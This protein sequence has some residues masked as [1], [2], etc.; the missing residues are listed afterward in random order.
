MVRNL[1]AKSRERVGYEVIR[2]MLLGGGTE[3]GGELNREGGGLPAKM[4][5]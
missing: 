4:D 5:E 1:V 3:R 2:V